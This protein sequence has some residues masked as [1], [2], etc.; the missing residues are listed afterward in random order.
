M[1]PFEIVLQQMLRIFCDAEVEKA[2]WNMCWFTTEGR[3]VV[4]G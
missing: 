3:S 1:G 4:D 2:G